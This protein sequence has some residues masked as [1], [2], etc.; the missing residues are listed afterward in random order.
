MTDTSNPTTEVTL[1]PLRS[2]TGVALVAA[3]V[4]AS[5]VGFLDA[6]MVNVAVPAIGHDLHASVAQLQWVLTGYL[7]TVASLLLLAGAFADHFG[8]RRV[9]GWRCQLS[10][11]ADEGAP[12]LLGVPVVMI[13]PGDP[14]EPDPGH[15]GSEGA[16][17]RCRA[18]L[19]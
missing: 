10:V 7:V 11:S 17:S 13:H 19:V 6:Y 12:P 8:R 2:R 4:L 9:R 1:F 3:T 14:D 18:H 16:G 5:T 15:G